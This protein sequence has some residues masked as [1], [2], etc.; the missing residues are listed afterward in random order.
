MPIAASPTRPNPLPRTTLPA[1]HPAMNPT[2]KMTISPSSDRCMFC[3]CSFALS[4]GAVYDI[5]KNRAENKLWEL[6]RL[7]DIVARFA[8]TEMT[9]AEAAFN[10]AGRIGAGALVA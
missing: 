1:S 2:T 5:A 7:V 8:N 4:R 6:T 3:P 10:E 9:V